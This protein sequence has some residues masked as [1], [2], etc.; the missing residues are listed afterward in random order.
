M[1]SVRAA[2]LATA[3]EYKLTM[4]ESLYDLAQNDYLGKL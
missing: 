3:T 1:T 4:N 2:A